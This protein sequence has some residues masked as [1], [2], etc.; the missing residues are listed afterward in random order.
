MYELL[1]KEESCEEFRLMMECYTGIPAEEDI[2]NLNDLQREKVA[3]FLEKHDGMV[4]GVNIN[5]DEYRP[6]PLFCISDVR[7]ASKVFC[8][9]ILPPAADRDKLRELVRLIKLW[10]SNR[11]LD[12]R[13]KALDEIFRL[14]DQ[15]GGVFL[16]WY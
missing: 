5:L 11:P 12:D 15:L 2:Q 7:D 1:S 14:I 16:Y 8:D 10:N 9:V 4:I 6:T 13:S 3:R